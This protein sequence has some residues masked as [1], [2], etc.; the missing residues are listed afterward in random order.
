MAS[1]T[2]P[3][4]IDQKC[5]KVAGKPCDPG[6]KGCVLHGRYVF[7]NPEKNRKVFKADDESASESWV[8]RRTPHLWSLP[9]ET[10]D[11]RTQQ[12]RM[13]C[14]SLCIRYIC[15]YFL[16]L[17]QAFYIKMKQYLTHF[18]KRKA[19]SLKLKKLRESWSVISWKRVRSA[20]WDHRW[21]A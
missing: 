4:E 6:M 8:I 11:L 15:I 16:K 12:I 21:S 7:S 14:L 3:H 19:I 2:C 18:S 1:W 17:I 5:M 10:H 9:L 20:V 13:I